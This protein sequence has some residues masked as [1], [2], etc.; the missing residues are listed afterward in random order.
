MLKPVDTLIEIILESVIITKL[1]PL[2]P[3]KAYATP[4]AEKDRCI[5]MKFRILKPPWNDS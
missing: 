4:R 3:H 2:Y 5:V 1:C